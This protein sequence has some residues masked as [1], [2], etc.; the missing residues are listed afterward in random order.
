MTSPTDR[1]LC[2]SMT[3]TTPYSSRLTS[4]RLSS[5]HTY[6][7]TFVGITK[8]SSGGRLP[9]QLRRHRRRQLT[10]RWRTVAIS[11]RIRLRWSTNCSNYYR[12]MEW[13][14]TM[15]MQPQTTRTT[16]V[17]VSRG[18]SVEAVQV[19]VGN[20][21]HLSST[22]TTTGNSNRPYHLR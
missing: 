16:T 2:T 20:H 12:S 21:S 7:T 18:P 5:R 3:K 17:M 6:S 15:T 13:P 14:Q 22:T 4:F 10:S 1:R 11:T 8:N 19:L 9:E